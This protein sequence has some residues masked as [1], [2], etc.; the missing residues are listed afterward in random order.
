MWVT[1]APGARHEFNSN[2][3]SDDDAL[4]NVNGYNVVYLMWATRSPDKSSDNV[5]K[6][7]VTSIANKLD[8]GKK[9]NTSNYTIVYLA[10]NIFQ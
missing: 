8:S 4:L 10:K 2:T 3:N 1:N 6:Q 5:M 9:N 7:L